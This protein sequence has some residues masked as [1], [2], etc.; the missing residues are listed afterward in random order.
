MNA[1]G[2]DG[3]RNWYFEDELT[4]RMYNLK[5]VKSAGINEIIKNG[6]ESVIG[7][8]LKVL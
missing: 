4:G 1:C 5:N 6:G 2:F 8:D 3:V 7:L